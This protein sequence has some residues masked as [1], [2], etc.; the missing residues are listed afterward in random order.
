[1]VSRDAKVNVQK[2][3]TL[4][5]VGILSPL[6]IH[7]TVSNPLPVP[8]CKIHIRDLISI[9]GWAKLADVCGKQEQ[10]PLPEQRDVISGTDQGCD[11]AYS[12]RTG[13]DVN[14]EEV[15]LLASFV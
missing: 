1:M 3:L 5:E 6:A 14:K 11:N 13:E 7:S 8:T 9:D 2:F 12:M 15:K 10:P 4:Y